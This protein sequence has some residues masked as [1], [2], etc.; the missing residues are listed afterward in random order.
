MEGGVGWWAQIEAALDQV[1]FLVIVMTP[2]AMA[3]AIISQ[4]W[5]YARQRGVV[6]YPVK[7]VP[8]DQLDYAAIPN[9]MR[10]A[11]FFD[12]G[13]F[14]GSEWRDAKEWQTFVNY[15]KSDRQPIRV[16]FMAPEL[17]HGFVAR[18]REFGQLLSL[19]LNTERE[20]AVAINTALQGPGGYGKTILAIA[21]C[22]DERVIDTFDDGVLWT[23][24]GQTPQLVDELA[25]LYDA[26]TGHHPAFVDVTHATA[27]LAEKLEHRNCLLVIDDVWDRAHLDPFLKGG[28]KCTRLVTTR[29]LD[30]V[31]GADLVRVDEMSAA[32][33]IR[34][35]GKRLSNQDA[36]RGAARAVGEQAGRMAVVAETRCRHDPQ[37]I[38]QRRLS[39]RCPHICAPRAGQARR[40]RLRP[41][42]D[43]AAR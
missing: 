39:K 35:S 19:L 13:R 37:T 8:D 34:L 12:I 20:H 32:E 2:K 42:Q 23:S 30:L 38:G 11:H 18:D 14:T 27:K 6:V 17:P 40:Y 41:G 31:S 43:G 25:K 10:K 9:W 4:E 21:V 16:P 26:L 15:L 7:G 33:S 36:F 5:R 29:R 24:L 1:K 22:H 3:S 28:K